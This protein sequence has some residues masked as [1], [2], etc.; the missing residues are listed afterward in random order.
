[1]PDGVAAPD[2]G[3]DR[4][5]ELFGVGRTDICTCERL[6]VA[7]SMKYR[8]SNFDQSGRGVAALRLIG[9]KSAVSFYY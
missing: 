3:F 4:W 9:L 2:L 5:P 1:V 7:P 6:M 8:R